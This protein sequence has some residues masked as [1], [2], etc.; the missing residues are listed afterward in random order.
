M[1]KHDKNVCLKKVSLLL[2]CFTSISVGGNNIL[3]GC[4]IKDPLFERTLPDF[5]PIMADSCKFF[6]IWEGCSPPSPLS[7]TPSMKVEQHKKVLPC[8]LYQNYHMKEA[9][10]CANTITLPFKLF[11]VLVKDTSL[12]SRRQSLESIIVNDFLNCKIILIFKLVILFV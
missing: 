5:C 11:E 9:I 4:P 7:P 6:Q 3:G 2:Y 1:S 10:L 12:R 8:K